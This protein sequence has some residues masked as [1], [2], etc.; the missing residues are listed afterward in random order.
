MLAC[1]VLRAVLADLHLGQ[2]TGDL[3]R[4]A[5][6]VDELLRRDAREVVLLGDLC[7]AL[8]G[9]PKFWDQVV[10]ATLEQLARL[11]RAGTRVVIVEGNRDFFLD[12][13]EIGRAVSAA[14]LVHSFSA[15]GTRFL[16][17]HGDLVNRGD[18][19][20]LFWRWLSKGRAARTWAWALPAGLATSIVRR[21]EAR[22]ARTNFSYRANLPVTRLE[23]SARRHFASGVDVVMWGH[24]HRSWRF[25]ED[26]RTAYVLPAWLDRGAMIW[27]EG[28]GALTL[29]VPGESGF[30]DTS[31][32]SWYQRTES[33][34]EVG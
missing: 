8:V 4:F 7:V 1:V 5:A 10:T 3:D 34:M 25:G 19:R 2:R 22:L 6:A 26:G 13:P 9:F 27:I 30:I 11:R 12:T 29:S 21:T 16:L 17:E 32:S 31:A 28:T 23:A 14:V 33:S 20:Y 18:H 24:F 15:G